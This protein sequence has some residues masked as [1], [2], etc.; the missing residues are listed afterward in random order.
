ECFRNAAKVYQ[1]GQ[2]FWDRFN[3]DPYSAYH[4]DNLYYP[5]TSHQ[6]WEL[7]SFLLCLSLSMATI[8]EF[9]ELKLI[10]AL[11]LSFR[12]ARELC[13]CA[14]LLPPVLK[15]QYCIVSTTHPT[16]QPLYFYWHDPLDCIKS[17]FSH[18]F[19]AKEID[20]MPQHVY[21]TV[22]CTSQ[23]Y[24]EWLMGDTVWS[25]QSQL[26]DGAT[27]LGVILSSDKTN[28]T[29]MTGG[30]VAHLLLISLANI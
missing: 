14:E 16:K 30:H 15:W 27:L 25:M 8:D 19:F 18:P 23:I 12:T 10:K 17:F 6:D 20:V 5:F 21:H 11:S 26:P 29:N 1:C 4:K 2:T 3:M 9:L 24:N 7:S 22:E 28:I 13:G